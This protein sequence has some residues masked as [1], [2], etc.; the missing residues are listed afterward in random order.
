M[1]QSTTILIVLFVMDTL[2]AQKNKK[3]SG[4]GN[5]TTIQ[6]TILDYDHIAI[7]GSF[8]IDLVEGSEGK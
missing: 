5:L 7:S 2:T 4:N 3:I 1:K 6:R 8:D